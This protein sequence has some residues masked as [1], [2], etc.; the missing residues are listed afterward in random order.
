MPA[1]GPMAARYLPAYP[2]PGKID[3]AE[4]EAILL[5]L[6]TYP[7]QLHIVSDS[8]IA[9]ALANGGNHGVPGRL[10]SPLA[11][12]GKARAGREVIVTWVKAH[13]G[14]PL[15]E[16]ADKQAVA[17]RR[18]GDRKAGLPRGGDAAA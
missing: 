2:T 18:C 1:T 3:Y 10:G 17:A 13:N 14:H 6:R 4:L 15:N 8:A 12:I 16:E 5:A 9:V 11:S 7:G